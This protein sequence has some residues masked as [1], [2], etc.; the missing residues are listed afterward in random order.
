MTTMPTRVIVNADDLGRTPGINDGIFAAHERGLV[1]SA[2]MMVAYPA[3]REAAARLAGYPA[4]GIGLHV[5]LSGGPPVLPAAELPSL[6]DDQGRFANHPDLFDDLDRG[7]IAAEVEAQF[8]KFRELTGRLP[9]HLDGH[10]HAHRH[11]LVLEAVMAVALREG[12]PVRN[13]SP[14]VA[15]KLRAAGIVTT[16]VFIERFYAAEARLGPLLEIIEGLAPGVTEVMCHP[17]RVDDELRQG[18]SYVDDREV[19][20]AVLTDARAKQALEQKGAR[21]IHFGSL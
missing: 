21:L 18:S 9:T 4:L 15:A 12:L 2:T 16:D 11:P 6:V 10:H 20:L 13:A 7:E 1:S 5:A 19:E 8:A 17:A 14:A 3:A